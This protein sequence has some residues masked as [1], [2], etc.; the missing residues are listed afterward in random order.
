MR[1][2][3][4]QK[5][6]KNIAHNLRSKQNSRVLGNLFRYAHTLNKRSNLYKT[7]GIQRF[8]SRYLFLGV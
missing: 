7:D 2:N 4:N 8:K 3:N 5:E 6:R 1:N